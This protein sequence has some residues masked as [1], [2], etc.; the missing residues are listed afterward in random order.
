MKTALIVFLSVIIL[1]SVTVRLQAQAKPSYTQYVLNNYILNPAI[2]GIE[3]YTDVKFS[4]RNQWTGING[5]PVTTYLSLHTPIGKKDSRT[6]PTSFVKKGINPRGAEY[7]NEYTAP[8]P[9]HGVGI[10]L[11]NDKAGYINRWSG[12]ISYAFHQ[13]LGVRTTLSAGIHMGAS[14]VNLDRS[15]INF[16]NLNPNDPAIG[17][18]NNELKK[19]RPEL[20]AGLWLYS[21]DYYA[22]I[23]VLNIIPGKNSFVNNDR[24]G[25]YYTPNYFLT[26]GYRFQVSEDMSLLPS[27]MFQYW[28]PQLSGLHT[29]V[30]LQYRDLLWT[31]ASYRF[32]NLVSGY[33]AMLG[34][35]IS[36]ALNASYSYEVSTTSR[37]R[38]YTGNTH[39]IMVGFI[40][41]NKYGDSCPRNVW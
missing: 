39:E 13:P 21:A 3:N 14:G 37:L 29:N 20:G 38:N 4:S 25:A 36:N 10:A 1:L 34:I 9:H 6:T 35:N 12:Y 11:L 18:A 7:W 8:D 28:Q 26:A 30:K 22:G 31:G 33:S 24:Y 23:S 32:S 2:T 41:G 15:K 27:F 40:L 5:A 17:Y 16:A 19:V